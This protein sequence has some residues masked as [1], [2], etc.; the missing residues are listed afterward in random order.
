VEH[1]WSRFIPE[2]G[3]KNLCVHKYDCIDTCVHPML[4]RLPKTP[5]F[6]SGNQVIFFG[7]LDTCGM[8]YEHS[9][10]IMT[11]VKVMPQFGASL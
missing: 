6:V 2:C 5:I 4:T 11:I 8:Y 3:K 1:V 10:I 9:M 7:F